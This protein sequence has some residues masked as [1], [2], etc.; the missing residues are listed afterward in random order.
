[1]PDKK[2]FQAQAI[3]SKIVT[4]H[5]KTLRLQ[6]DCL[7][8]NSQDEAVLFSA[9]HASG[10]FVFAEQEIKPEDITGLPDITIE[11][12]EKHPSARLKAVLY[13]LWQQTDKKQDFEVFY[14]AKMDKIIE[15]M[16]AKLN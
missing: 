15:A 6:V 8:M 12:H 11:K 4:L 3:I 5:D 14:R 10:W 13:L 9:R 7:E 2:L 1:M 16:K